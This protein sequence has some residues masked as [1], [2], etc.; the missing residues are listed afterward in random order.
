MEKTENREEGC[1]GS[2]RSSRDEAVVATIMA[3]LGVCI[4]TEAACLE[5]GARG[6]E[7][8]KRGGQDRTSVHGAKH[9]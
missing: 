4:R 1:T 7:Q 2:W 5:E 8:V 6:V 9:K 3:G